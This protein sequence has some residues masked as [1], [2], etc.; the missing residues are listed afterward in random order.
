MLVSTVEL[1]LRAKRANKLGIKGT[2]DLSLDWPTVIARKDAIVASWSKGKN[3]TPA[4][5]GIPVL[6][7]RG[8][9][10]GRN[11]INVSE[12]NYTADKFVIAIG[13][14]PARPAIP[15][16]ELGITSDEL[17]HLKE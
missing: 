7:G 8:V 2:E 12:R 17:I 15:G 11:E 3:A 13:S 6:P 1:F 5:L 9:F 16:A 14:K 4:K 10:A